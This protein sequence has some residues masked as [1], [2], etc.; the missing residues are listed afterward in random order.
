MLVVAGVRGVIRIVE[1]ERPKH[2]P[3]HLIGH[4]SAVNQLKISQK[5]PF[6]LAS[7]SKDRSI[8]LW[9]VETKACIATFHAIESHRDEVVSIDFNHDCTRLVS[10]G[11]D[12][13]IAIWDLTIPEIVDTIE[14]SKRYD[15]KKSNKAIKTVYHP[16]PIFSTRSLHSNYV[17]SVKW[18]NEFI[19]SKVRIL[20]IVFF[21]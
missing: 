19:I 11:I 7:A 21:F 16:F 15:E 13:M 1:V 12:H 14:K 2:Q 5:N 6:L 20:K 8:R 9:N 3:G 17:D 18:H 10:G 4:G